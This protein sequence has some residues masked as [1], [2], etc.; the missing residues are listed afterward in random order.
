L[1]LV[2]GLGNPGINYEMTRHN[3]GFFAVDT[4]LEFLNISLKPGKGDWYA[5]EARYKDE[6]FCIMKPTTYMNRSGDAVLNFSEE[7]NIPVND[8]LVVY[9]DFQLPLGM[10]RIR[11]KGSDGGHNGISS[12][13]YSLNT[14][15]F[16]RMRIGIG[17]ENPVTVENYTD[18]VLSK[19]QKEELEKL[20]ILKP[21]LRD[22]I[23]TFISEGI[24]NTMNR[25]NRNFLTPSEQEETDTEEN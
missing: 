18:F 22:S 2:V 7:R 3:A 20:E 8:I 16:P 23:L 5:A 19:F 9:D 24:F 21:Y 17:N 15:E 25:Y 4:V 6:L 10:L 11:R 12:I 14:L 1:K 13:I